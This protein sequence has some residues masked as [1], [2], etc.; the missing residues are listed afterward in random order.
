MLQG[1]SLVDVAPALAALGGCLVVC[2]ALAMKMF[3]W[4]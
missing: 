4:R 1:A 2:F 3:R